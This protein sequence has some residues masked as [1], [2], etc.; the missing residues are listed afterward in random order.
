MIDIYD[1]SNF[2]YMDEPLYTVN[3][4]ENM[5][6]YQKYDK[7]YKR[8][9]DEDIGMKTIVLIRQDSNNELIHLHNT[10][11]LTN[12]Q[13]INIFIK[14]NNLININPYNYYINTYD[15][16]YIIKIYPL[17][18]KYNTVLRHLI[19]MNRDQSISRYC[20]FDIKLTGNIKYIATYMIDIIPIT[21]STPKDL[22]M[23]QIYIKDYIHKEDKF[24]VCFKIFKLDQDYF[25][26]YIHYIIH[27]EKKIYFNKFSQTNKIIRRISIDEIATSLNKILYIHKVTIP[28]INDIGKYQLC[29]YFNHID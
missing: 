1:L 8:L 19:Y 27:D 10:N 21:N 28:I 5:Q 26:M 4:N 7:I 2:N 24:I 6:I 11:N 29:Y 18:Y 9:F 13:S 23:S 22:H 14:T 3:I 25:R 12:I 16:N 15:S 20:I 17:N